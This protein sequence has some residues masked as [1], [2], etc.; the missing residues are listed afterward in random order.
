MSIAMFIVLAVLAFIIK[1][2]FTPKRVTTMTPELWER[3]NPGIPYP[4]D[5]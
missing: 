5:N 2:A 3:L 4:L 1:N